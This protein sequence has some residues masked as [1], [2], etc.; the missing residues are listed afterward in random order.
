M[1][2]EDLKFSQGKIRFS[3]EEIEKAV[4]QDTNG[5]FKWRGVRDSVKPAGT[6]PFT[7][8]MKP[9]ITKLI[10]IENFAEKTVQNSREAFKKS[11]SSEESTWR[12]YMIC[13]HNFKISIW[14]LHRLFRLG[15]PLD[16]D[17]KTKCETCCK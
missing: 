14:C 6:I 4:Y 2:E 7:K 8:L 17:V 9:K 16:F 15:L 5:S 3:V 1:A 12:G 11:G 10:G 13:P